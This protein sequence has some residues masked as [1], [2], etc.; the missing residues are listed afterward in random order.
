MSILN[1]FKT[2]IKK[3]T[4]TGRLNKAQLTHLRNMERLQ[5][6]SVKIFGKDFYFTDSISFIDTYNEIFEKG[7]YKF[8]SNASQVSDKIIIDCGANIGLS[9][10]FFSQNYPDHTIKAFEPDPFIFSILKKNIESFGITN[11]ELYNKAVW[12]SETTLS[13]YSDG[14]MAGNLLK[15]ASEKVI[16]V[17]T[18]RL[19]QFLQTKVDLLKIDIEGA[20]VEVIKDCKS[21]LSNANKI[22]IEYHSF[23]EQEQQLDEMILALKLSGFRTYIHESYVSKNPFVEVNTICDNMDMALNIFAV[24]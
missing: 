4:A 24:K 23:S 3:E 8:T 15:G 5:V 2:Y 1:G 13:F 21:E 7:I 14:A 12:S 9:V 17:E 10:V 18:V 11:V 20:E 16:N 22:F 6:G 19:K